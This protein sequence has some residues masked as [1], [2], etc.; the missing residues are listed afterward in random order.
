MKLNSFILFGIVTMCLACK[1]EPAKVVKYIELNGKTMGTTYTIKYLDSLNRNFK[2]AIDSLLIALN[3][4]VSTYEPESFISLFNKSEAAF[5]YLN[6]LDK[7]A[8]MPQHFKANFEKSKEVFE[9]SEGY[10][11][12]TVMPIVNYWGFGY[13]EKRPVEQIDSVKVDSLMKLV[14]FDKITQQREKD[15]WVYLIKDSPGVQLDF[16]AIAKGYGVD[17]VAILL[18]EKD[19]ENY[20]VEIGGELIAHGKNPQ[21][22]WWTIGINTPSEK[23]VITDF[24]SKI[25]LQ[26]QAV[27]TSGNYRNFYEVNGKKYA[28]TLNP[29]TGYP[30]KNTLLSATVF[31]NDC[32][33][34]D[35][36]A[37]ACMAMGL[38][39]A[40][41]M[42]NKL[43]GVEA[44][45]LYSDLK[46]KVLSHSTNTNL[47]IFE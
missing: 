11:D 24:Q 39:K 35:A 34:A 41:V 31:A 8:K 14:G 6:L 42:I 45:F 5:K 12:P 27:A 40:T 7:G 10:F 17:M 32:M 28:H 19:L 18:K 47:T 15:G 46:G 1:N 9:N 20:Y 4:E 16:S 44:Y 38:E 37:T 13:T 23:A 25:A 21:S 43:N 3:N 30:E 36:Y 2:P 33:T 29:K 26:N 22:N